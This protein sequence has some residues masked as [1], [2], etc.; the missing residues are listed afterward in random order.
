MYGPTSQHPAHR[1]STQQP[2]S[3]GDCRPI[4]KS[5][6]R[7]V[8]DAE[9]TDGEYYFVHGMFSKKKALQPIGTPPSG[10]VVSAGAVKRP[11]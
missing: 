4:I 3:S 11:F 7:R 1:V 5:N 9:V 6:C 8:D 2:Q 10:L